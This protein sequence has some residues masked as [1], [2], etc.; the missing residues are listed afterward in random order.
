MI[1]IEDLLKALRDKIE[2]RFVTPMN[3]NA[4]TFMVCKFT[5]ANIKT[6]ISEEIKCGVYLIGIVMP[7]IEEESQKVFHEF[8]VCYFG[9]S[10]KNLQN[11]ICDHLANGGNSEE[12]HIY[13][14]NL[15]FAA[16]E[17]E[18]EEEAYEEECQYFDMFLSDTDIRREG[19]GYSNNP[20]FS[21]D[22]K[23]GNPYFLPNLVY[24]DNKDKPAHP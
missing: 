16:W 6:L 7:R 11:R 23:K 22:S 14:E 1:P 2:I 12:L 9:R 3:V 24:I 18:S 10:D 8:R 13:G 19:N 4:G 17:C 15:Y 21:H 20:K 5:E